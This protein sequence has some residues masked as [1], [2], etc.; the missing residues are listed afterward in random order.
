MADVQIDD[1]NFTQVANIL[2]EKVSGA[3]MNGCQHAIVLQVWR[4]T[5][6]FKRKQHDL[7]SGF[8]AKATGYNKRQIERELSKLV[9]RKIIF[10]KIN[11]G[12]SRTL[13]FNKDYEIWYTPGELADGQKADGQLAGTPPANKP[14]VTPGELADQEIKFKQN[15]KENIYTQDFEMFWTEYPKKISKKVAFKKWKSLMKERVEPRTIIQCAINY[16]KTCKDRKTDPDFI[17]HPSTFLNDDRYL[18]FE[19]YKQMYKTGIQTPKLELVTVSQEEGERLELAQKR[20][21][22]RNLQRNAAT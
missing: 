12:V 13:S 10:Q 7:S 18:D 14:T 3:K 19:T 2:L 15:L 21:M 5:Y 11:N 9:D 20:Q 8:L 16:S 4:Y 1:G 17:K 6:G 22:E